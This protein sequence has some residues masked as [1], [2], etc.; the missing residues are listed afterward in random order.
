MTSNRR[1]MIE[2]V[3]RTSKIQWIP[4]P[5]GVLNI[6]IDGAVSKVQNTGAFSAVCRDEQ[7][8]FRGCSSVMVEGI[9]NHVCFRSNGM[10]GDD[11][12]GR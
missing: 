12:F 7:G 3:A 5:V 9:S 10:R 4:P 8:C 11:V 6:N 1:F 2:G